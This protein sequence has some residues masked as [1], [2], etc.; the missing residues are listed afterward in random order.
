VDVRS[1]TA[2]LQRLEERLVR[3]DQ[4]T[5]V[6]TAERYEVPLPT[7]HHALED[8][9]AMASLFLIPPRS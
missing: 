4:L 3:N 8:A 6:A 7:P 5:L 1:L 2:V 9:V